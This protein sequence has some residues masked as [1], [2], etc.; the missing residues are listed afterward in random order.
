MARNVVLADPEATAIYICYEH[1]RSHLMSRLLCLESAE[2]GYRDDALT[3]RKIGDLSLNAPE[4]TGL[5]EPVAA[6]PAATRRWW[7]PCS[8]TVSG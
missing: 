8:A 5:V 6:H 1:D 4:G 3:L 2:A 7:T